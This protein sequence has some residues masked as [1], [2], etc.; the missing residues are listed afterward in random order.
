MNIVTQFQV[1]LFAIGGELPVHEQGS[2]CIQADR[3][4][5]VNIHC[6]THYWIPLILDRSWTSGVIA[7]LVSLN[8]LSH[9]IAYNSSSSLYH[10]ALVAMVHQAP[11]DIPDANLTPSQR[12]YRKSVSALKQSGD[13]ILNYI[14]LQESQDTLGEGQHLYE[15][16]W[17]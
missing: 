13:I 9:T 10:L 4:L 16:V 3:E 15:K 17:L 11:K 12:F 1:H 2:F 5:V 8:L 14:L 6:R 7:Q